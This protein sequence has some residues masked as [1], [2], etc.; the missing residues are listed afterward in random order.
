MGRLVVNGRRAGGCVWTGAN[1]TRPAGGTKTGEREKRKIRGYG[2]LLTERQR[3]DG[4]VFT[5]RT[6]PGVVRRWPCGAAPVCR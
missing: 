1:E 5:I 3:T 6:F 4:R 2:T